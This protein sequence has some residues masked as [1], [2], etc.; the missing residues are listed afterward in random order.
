MVSGFFERLFLGAFR[1]TK[2]GGTEANGG[3]FEGKARRDVIGRDKGR[4]PTFER[5][6][7]GRRS[8]FAGGGLEILGGA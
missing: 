1:E 4:T 6:G 8:V 5:D 3:G 7:R 2:G